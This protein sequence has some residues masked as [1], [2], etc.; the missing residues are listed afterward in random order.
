MPTSKLLN[1]EY[2]APTLRVKSRET[3]TREFKQ[4]YDKKEVAD[5]LR[6]MAAMANGEG[7]DIIF[8]VT[9]SPRT[10]VG[11]EEAM[12]DAANF[13]S[14]VTQ[15]FDPFI[16][17]EIDE[18]T[19]KGKRVGI[20]RVRESKQKPVICKKVRTMKRTKGKKEYDET[21]LEEAA[22]YYR[23]GPKSSKIHFND[24]ERLLKNRQE[25][26]LKSILQNFEIMQKIGF[27]NVGIVDARASE[28]GADV[29]SL[30]VSEETAKNLNLIKKG[31][32]VE[33]KSAGSPAYY[34]VGEVELKKGIEV[35]IPDSDRV[36]L[37]EAKTKLAPTFKKHFPEVFTGNKNLTNA[38]LKHIACS[39]KLR[40]KKNDGKH[41]TQYCC[42]DAKT[43]RFFYR[44]A[45]LKLIENKIKTSKFDMG[46]WLQEA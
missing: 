41:N 16:D 20:I 43:R 18:E 35:A 2:D 33:D 19:I 40:D 25:N 29:S 26:E 8:G 34:I 27:Q 11:I 37:D 46:K 36:F 45:F 31:Q 14:S 24:L 15:H 4:I 38:Q 21:V 39:L 5:Y 28:I 30:Y 6:A 22:I 13:G 9:D 44:N 23:Y 42:Y 10:I 17:F 7:G 1:I 12:P 32:L 3:S